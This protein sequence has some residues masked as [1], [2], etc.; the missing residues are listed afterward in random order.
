MS[1]YGNI[2]TLQYEYETVCYL[3]SYVHLDRIEN[4]LPRTLS[5][6]DGGRLNTGDEDSTYVSYETVYF[7][8]KLLYINIIFNRYQIQ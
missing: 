8:H 1:L 6:I 5:V 2:V 3:S 4:Y 7:Q